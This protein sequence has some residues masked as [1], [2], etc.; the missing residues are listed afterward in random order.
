[1][2]LAYAYGFDSYICYAEVYPESGIAKVNQSD[3]LFCNFYFIFS[4][5]INLEKLMVRIRKS[6]KGGERL[7]Y[8]AYANTVQLQRVKM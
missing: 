5:N 2:A 3:T 6:V 7:R 8:L 4:T 1:M